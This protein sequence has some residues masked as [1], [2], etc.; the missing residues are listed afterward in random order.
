MLEAIQET[1][2]LILNSMRRGRSNPRSNDNEARR[3]LLRHVHKQYTRGAITRLWYLQTVG[4]HCQLKLKKKKVT[5]GT[6]QKKK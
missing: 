4:Y 1:T 5:K 3:Q 2:D 6:S